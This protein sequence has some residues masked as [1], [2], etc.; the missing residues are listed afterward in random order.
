MRT[1]VAV[2]GLL[3]CCGAAC[4]G[5]DHSGGVSSWIAPPIEE[6]PRST[7]SL[8]ELQGESGA[9][10]NVQV[11]DGPDHDALWRVSYSGA[12]VPLQNGHGV[13]R[14]SVMY[15]RRKSAMGTFDLD[16]PA[17]EGPDGTA[18]TMEVAYIEVPE[19]T[20]DPNGG[21]HFKAQ[22][23]TLELQR[24]GDYDLVLTF[25]DVSFV[26]AHVTHPQLLLEVDMDGMPKVISGQVSALAD[27]DCN[28]PAEFC[29]DQHL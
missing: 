20:I 9:G 16:S 11:V 15:A 10:F 22:T 6:T 2:V 28:G 4:S 12:N 29:A 21:D 1:L 5:T 3:L 7:L 13:G 23:G 26:P 27:F 8:G 17:I 14:V 18:E 19:G 25:T 24:G